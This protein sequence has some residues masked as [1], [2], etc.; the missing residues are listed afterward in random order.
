MIN[1]D[2]LK[3]KDLIWGHISSESKVT[4]CYLVK[5]IVTVFMCQRQLCKKLFLL[6]LF[7]AIWQRSDILFV[8][9]L[10]CIKLKNIRYILYCI[11]KWSDINFCMDFIEKSLGSCNQSFHSA[12]VKCWGTVVVLCT[13]EHHGNVQQKITSRGKHLT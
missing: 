6:H 13:R 9:F 11:L 12:S 5:W 3:F 1:Y 4:S 10:F 8:I 7:L 2:K